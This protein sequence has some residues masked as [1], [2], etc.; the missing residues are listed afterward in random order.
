MLQKGFFLSKIELTL[1]S[2]FVRNNM[3]NYENFLFFALMTDLE[4]IKMGHSFQRQ[5]WKSQTNVAENQWNN[6]Y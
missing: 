5:I 2:N 3:F 1:H 6:Y 4:Y